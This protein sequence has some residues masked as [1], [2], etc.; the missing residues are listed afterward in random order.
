MKKPTCKVCK[1]IKVNQQEWKTPEE[2]EMCLTCFSFVRF[3]QTTL[4]NLQVVV[5]YR[6]INRQIFFV[7]KEEKLTP[8]HKLLKAISVKYPESRVRIIDIKKSSD[9]GEPTNQQKAR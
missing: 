1:N 5:D 9:E 2:K 3:L 4:E 7:L 8:E 6:G